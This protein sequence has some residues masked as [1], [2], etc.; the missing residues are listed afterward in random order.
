[1]SKKSHSPAPAEQ[2]GAGMSRIARPLSL[3]QQVEQILR[4]AIQ[5]NRFV[6]DRLP[7]RGRTGRP[8]RREPRNGPPGNR[9]AGARGWSS[10]FGADL[11]E[12]LQFDGVHVDAGDVPPAEARRLVGKTRIVGTFGGGEA[13]LPVLDEPVDYFAVG[14]VFLTTT[15]Q[16]YKEPM[17][18]RVYAGCGNRLGRT[19][20]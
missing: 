11:V 1:M 13:L 15:K 6:G 4:D 20:F 5:T 12:Q 3:V 9:D 10:S 7:D 16:T 14:P 19:E 8:A 18:R 2:P 17:G